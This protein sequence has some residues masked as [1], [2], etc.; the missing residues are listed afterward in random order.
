MKSVT[1]LLLG[2]AVMFACAG[3]AFA[4][5]GEGI[6]LGDWMLR[7]YGSVEVRGDSNVGLAQD[8]EESDTSFVEEI[9]LSVSHDVNAWRA[10]LGVWF[11]AEQYSD[12]DG[13]DHEDWGQEFSFD[14]ETPGSFLLEI[15]QSYSDVQD[16]D[17]NVGARENFA[18]SDASIDL[19]RKLGDRLTGSVG[20]DYSS[21]DYESDELFD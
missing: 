14:I 16:I 4:G 11:L 6:N 19:S 15:E 8:N 13:L 21:K 2:T 3:G 7:P 12:F 20:F 5:P 17:F 9:G 10:E 18:S 1:K